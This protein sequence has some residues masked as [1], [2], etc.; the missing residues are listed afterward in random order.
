MIDCL[1]EFLSVWIK[2]NGFCHLALLISCSLNTI[3]LF[4]GI[5]CACGWLFFRVIL[6]LP[7]SIIFILWVMYL[8]Y[9]LKV[10]FR[11]MHAL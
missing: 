6:I 3:K 5:L 9:L 4:C 10:V 11:G 7:F 1:Y 8:F 2:S